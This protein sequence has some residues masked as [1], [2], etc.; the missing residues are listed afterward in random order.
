[1][2][3]ELLLFSF[4]Y[5]FLTIYILEYLIE[6]ICDIHC[7]K[8]QRLKR[9][10][11]SGLCPGSRDGKYFSR[12]SFLNDGSNFALSKSLKQLSKNAFLVLLKI[13]RKW[14]SSQGQSKLSHRSVF[15]S[16]H[17]VKYVK[18]NLLIQ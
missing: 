11:A 17:Q 6:V 1:M 7:N 15:S 12:L 13:Q 3:L 5:V 4:H 2:I 16:L 10:H 14:R 9:K 18:H 8:T